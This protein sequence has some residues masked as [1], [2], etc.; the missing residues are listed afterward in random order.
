[1]QICNMD[2]TETC[3]AVCCINV[4]LIMILDISDCATSN[5]INLTLI[6]QILDISDCDTGPTLVPTVNHVLYIC[7]CNFEI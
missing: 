2:G 4:T 7:L 5:S 6:M 3:G 1:M